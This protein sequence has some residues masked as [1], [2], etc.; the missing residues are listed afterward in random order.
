MVSSTRC[1]IDG[2]VVIQSSDGVGWYTLIQLNGC[3]IKQ[4]ITSTKGGGMRLARKTIRRHHD[5]NGR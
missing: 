4:H 3:K 5:R 2:Y 1:E